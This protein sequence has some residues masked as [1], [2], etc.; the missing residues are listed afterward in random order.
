[1]ALNPKH[2]NAFGFLRR[3]D[4]ARGNMDRALD[5]DTTFVPFWSDFNW[6][7]MG[8]RYRR[9]QECEAR[10]AAFVDENAEEGAFQVA[11]IY[12]FAG[13][14]D[15][16]FE[17]LELSVKQRDPGLTDELL[18]TETLRSLHDDS[19]WEPLVARLGLLEAYRAMPARDAWPHIGTAKLTT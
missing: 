8:Y 7:L 10:L 3:I 14:A 15:I 19:R 1:M 17:W 12:A 5:R 13:E 2:H 16:A 4:A 6:L 11:E 18:S 9:T